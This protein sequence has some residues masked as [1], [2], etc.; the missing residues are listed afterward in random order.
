MK[1]VTL[2]EYITIHGFTQKEWDECVD[3]LCANGIAKGSFKDY[4]LLQLVISWL[5]NYNSTIE[6]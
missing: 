5:C 4:Y 1:K 3:E 6:D 2:G